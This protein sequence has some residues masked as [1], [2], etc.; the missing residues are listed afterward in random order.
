MKIIGI[1]KTQSSADWVAYRLDTPMS[2]EVA[3]HFRRL[4][5]LRTESRGVEMK[6]LNSLV[7]VAVV[8]MPKGFANFIS[9]LLAQAENLVR[10]EKERGRNEESLE[11]RQKH[12]TLQR[13]ANE[14]QLPIV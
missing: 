12:E 3:A 9:Q 5:S 4:Y 8:N 7:C 13:I 6:M 10:Q 2:D 11:A 1:D 14:E